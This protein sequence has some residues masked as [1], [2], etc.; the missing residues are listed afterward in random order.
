MDEQ[1]HEE[2]SAPHTDEQE[3]QPPQRKTVNAVCARL[4]RI[5]GVDYA[6]MFGPGG[7]PLE[8]E[9]G[10]AARLAE[11]GESLVN[12]ASRLGEL[13]GVGSLKALAR[14]DSGEQQLLF[15][16]KNV[17]I[18]LAVAGGTQMSQVEAEIRSAFAAKR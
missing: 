11:Q 9:S 3:G 15:E 17:H 1:R 14:Q 4:M 8:D 12:A 6:V 18:A 16:A 2:A 10:E 7:A 13:F 5:P